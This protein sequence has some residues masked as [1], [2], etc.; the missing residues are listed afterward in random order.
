MPE[1]TTATDDASPQIL[2]PPGIL[3]SSSDSVVN[4]KVGPPEKPMPLN[5]RKSITKD[6][7]R[8]R[9]D[10]TVDTIEQGTLVVAAR[11]SSPLR[12]TLQPKVAPLSTKVKQQHLQLPSFQALGIANPYPPTILTP[13]EEPTSLDWTSSDVDHSQLTPTAASSARRNVPAN[14][15]HQCLFPEGSIRAASKED[16]TP[17]QASVGALI[18]PSVPSEQEPGSNS[19]SSSTATEVSSNMPWLTGA[20][21]TV[22]SLVPSGDHATGEVRI[23][24]QVQPRPLPQNVL[25]VPSALTGVINAL[26]ATFERYSA[27]RYIDVTYAVPGKYSFGQLPSSPVTTPNR[28]A[29]AASMGDYFSMPKT[30]VYAK[31]TYAATYSEACQNLTSNPTSRGS[32]QTLVAPSTIT[33]STLER[34]IPPA[35][36][37]EYE[38]LFNM[39][40]PSALVDRMSE[41]KPDNGCMVFIYPTRQGA[42]TFKHNYVG[43]ILGPV[44]ST[45]IG[46]RSIP[47]IVAE[48]INKLEAIDVMSQFKA[49]VGRINRLII[50]MNNK[51]NGSH[52]KFKIAM[53]SKETVHLSRG[54]W[55]EWFLEQEL[56]R[57]RHIIDDYYGRTPGRGLPQAHNQDYTAAGMVGEI[58]DGIKERP[59]DGGEPQEGIEVGVFVIK[60]ER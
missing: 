59:Y 10:V 17:T 29:A 3:R 7:Q 14:T 45:M 23:L 8:P 40:E 50:A 26:Q 35:T 30:V 22:L 6:H 19:S 4:S 25:V 36:R 48:R 39:D 44:L 37:R 52:Q 54:V 12:M 15:T 53:A 46:V 28:P 13:P 5:D 18:S 16:S 24:N 11:A 41:L 57:F 38:D 58:I 20:L 2:N 33:I 42:I 49:L 31:G 1:Q 55:A 34:F 43:P 51:G 47:E 56:P 60:R 9:D 32:P 27:T 21:G